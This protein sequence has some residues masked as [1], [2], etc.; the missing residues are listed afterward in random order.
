MR[1]RIG[2]TMS[3]EERTRRR[4]GARRRKRFNG[5]IGN[6]NFGR[7]VAKLV[8][9]EYTALRIMIDEFMKP[10]EYKY[11]EGRRVLAKRMQ[12]QVVAVSIALSGL[13]QKKWIKKYKCTGGDVFGLLPERV[14]MWEEA[15]EKVQ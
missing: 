3:M 12:C 5:C 13:M 10:E 1:S 6:S 8:D 15:H 2:S 4:K 14:K 7:E 11:G 9:A